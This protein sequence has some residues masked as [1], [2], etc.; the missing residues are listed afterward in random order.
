MRV[1]PCH[2]ET[3]DLA[4]AEQV[5]QSREI[6]RPKAFGTWDDTP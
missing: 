3:S 4:L 5:I 6:P 2:R 1:A